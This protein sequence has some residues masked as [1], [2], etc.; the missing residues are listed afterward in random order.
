MD[1]WFSFSSR[2][3][4]LVENIGLGSMKEL[5]DDTEY[6]F[7]QVNGDRPHNKAIGAHDIK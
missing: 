7:I 2:G 6:R 3:C 5:E 1:L 4:N